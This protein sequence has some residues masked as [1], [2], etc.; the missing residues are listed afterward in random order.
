ML[1]LNILKPREI[2]MSL[3]VDQKYN[4]YFLLYYYDSMANK[5]C[6]VHI[7]LG[8]ISKPNRLFAIFLIIHLKPI[9]N[10]QF[11]HDLKASFISKIRGLADKFSKTCLIYYF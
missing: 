3:K 4:S 8:D 9:S 7:H 6:L 1:D 2:I 5:F 11:F 10:F